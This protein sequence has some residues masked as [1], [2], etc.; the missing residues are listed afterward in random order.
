MNQS[1]H[2]YNISIH[3]VSSPASA[4]SDGRVARSWHQ[5]GPSSL[6]NVQEVAGGAVLLYRNRMY[7]LQG[8]RWWTVSFGLDGRCRCEALH[9]RETTI[10]GLEN[11]LFITVTQHLFATYSG[12]FA[13]CKNSWATESA[14]SKLRLGKHTSAQAQ[15][16]HTPTL[17]AGSHVTLSLCDLPDPTM[18]LCFSVRIRAKAI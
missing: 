15:W 16:R 12:I 8:R 18:E 14:V 6:Y 1:T 7:P 2:A 9:T 13:P 10:G 3:S 17:L 5:V 4:D 11:R